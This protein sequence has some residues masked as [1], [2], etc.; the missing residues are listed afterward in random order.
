MKQSKYV[1]IE[2][3]VC[4]IK[5]ISNDIIIC[6]HKNSDYDSMCSSL[7][8]AISLKQLK[9]NVKV[10]IEPESINKVEYFNCNELLCDNIDLSD[11]T[12]IA[13]D[14]NRVSRLPDNMEKCYKNANLTINIDHHNENTTNADFILSNCEIS[15]TCEIIYNLLKKMKININKKISELIFTGIVSDTN[16]FSNTTSSKTFLIVS[17]L[18]KK[19]IDN[20]F[21]IKKFY[22][23]KSQEELK[24][25]AYK[26]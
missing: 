24:I 10:Y 12:F 5:D 1:S 13:L 11:Y 21:L 26:I 6:G 14:L 20:E 17:N 4:V 8:L 9:K 25:I 15:S 19:K 2:E 18:L 16:L 7:A 3:L 23:E 22:L